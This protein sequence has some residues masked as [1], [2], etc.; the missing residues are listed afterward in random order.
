MKTSKLFKT[1]ALAMTFAA[2]AMTTVPA[3][4]AVIQAHAGT[5]FTLTPVEFDQQGNPTKFSHTV[6]GVVRVS[7][8]GNCTG[9][10]DI[11]AV[12]RPDGTFGLAGTLQI[13]S[14]D[15]QTTLNGE[16]EGATSPEPANALMANFH[17]DVKFT[18]G[19]G[20][21]AKARGRGDIDGFALFNESFAGGK[22]T[23]LMRGHVFA[24]GKGQKD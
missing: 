22:A 10:F 12:P 5:T 18:G 2:V 4:A 13:T 9:H 6:D 17:Y 16:V 24:R 8:L 11:V 7:L 3:E 1:L 14:A 19:T 15:G 21:M 23:W 20:L